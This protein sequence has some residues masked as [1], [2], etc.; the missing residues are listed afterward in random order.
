MIYHGT[1]VVYGRVNIGCGRAEERILLTGLHAVADIY[2]NSCKT[3]L[4]WKYVSP[5]T[6]INLVDIILLLLIYCR[7]MHL[8]QVKS[9][10]KE[11]S[12]SN[13]HTWSKR[14]VGSSL[15]YSCVSFK[16]QNSHQDHC[17]QLSVHSF[18]LPWSASVC[19]KCS[20]K[21]LA[22]TC[23]SIHAHILVSCYILNCQHII[24]RTLLSLSHSTHD[25][26]YQY[27]PI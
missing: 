12:S 11:N 13:W 2:C 3:T 1:F 22:H 18:V 25:L 15:L 6:S 26:C 24:S 17:L 9:T 8:R 19:C 27:I 20:A 21:P 7:S 4:G 16:P 23:A 10:R 5:F 14:M